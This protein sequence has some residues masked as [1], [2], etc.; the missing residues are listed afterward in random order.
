M[1]ANT[2]ERFSVGASPLVYCVLRLKSLMENIDLLEHML[3]DEKKQFQETLAVNYRN[4]Y[5]KYW[6]KF[7]P[8]PPALD[9]TEQ[10]LRAASAKP[11]TPPTNQ[12][13]QQLKL[14]F[15]ASYDILG[16]LYDKQRHSFLHNQQEEKKE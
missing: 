6:P 15:E 8:T 11:S 10:F 14:A 12:M 7:T 13:F 1:Q 4:L 5:T 3:S 9:T 16:K 2:E